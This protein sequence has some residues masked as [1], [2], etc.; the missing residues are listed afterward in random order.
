MKHSRQHRRQQ[1]VNIYLKTWS[2]CFILLAATGLLGYCFIHLI[3]MNKYTSSERAASELQRN[4]E[5]NGEHSAGKTEDTFGKANNKVI[6]LTIDD[7][8]SSAT[9]RILDALQKV[10]AKATFFMLAP[11]IKVHPE[12]V[13]RMIREGNGAGLHGVTHVAEHFYHSKQTVLDE[14][15]EDQKT[16]E[17]V[18]DYHSVLVRVPYGSVPYLIP[19]FRKALDSQGYKL[20]DW[21]VDSR[22]WELSNG[23]FVES[24]INQIHKVEKD[25]ERTVVLLHDREETAKYLPQLLSYLSKQGYQMKKIDA[26]VKP[27][28][29]HC[30]DRCYSY[31]K[32]AR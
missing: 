26:S 11:H 2:I 25:G 10:N 24:T 7:G 8:P 5:V 15:S 23:G 30:Y 32:K 18:A 21:T 20:W 28:H 13:K 16:L 3:A 9:G 12:V 31:K 29:F 14:I 19:S 6:Y 27:M 4:T 1:R 22:D 17:T